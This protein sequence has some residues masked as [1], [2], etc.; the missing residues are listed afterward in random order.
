MKLMGSFALL[1]A[2]LAVTAGAGAGAA[3]AQRAMLGA[4]SAPAGVRGLTES[5][6]SHHGAQRGGFGRIGG[7]GRHGRG[8]S[9]G[10][11]VIGYGGNLIV[12]PD[13]YEGDDGFFAGSAD[14][15]VRGGRAAYDYDRAYPYDWYRDVPPARSQERAAIRHSGPSE[16]HCS[17]ERAAVRVCRG[18]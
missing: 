12:D 15:S 6:R 7:I 9:G 16:V 8:L 5:I 4:R 14:A 10:I 13:L 17:V 3:H 18:G 11:G 2:A 1:A